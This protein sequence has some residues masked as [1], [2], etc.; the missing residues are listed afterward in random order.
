MIVHHMQHVHLVYV[1]P[2]LCLTKCS[3]LAG[4]D[5]LVSTAMNGSPPTPAG[6]LFSQGYD[7]AQV[8]PN[9]HNMFSEGTLS[10]VPYF[11]IVT[12]TIALHH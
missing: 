8:V 6:R 5:T 2:A 12:L 1:M 3:L 9:L 4:L 10:K 11:C 7:A